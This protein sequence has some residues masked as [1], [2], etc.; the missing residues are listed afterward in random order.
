[1]RK[2]I[3]SILLS[4][5]LVANATISEGTIGSC[6][7]SVDSKTGILKITGNGSM[8]DVSSEKSPLRYYK[9]IVKE[10]YI[11][12]GV[13]DIGR[14]AFYNFKQLRSISIPNTVTSIG[15][16][17]F[18]NCTNLES[19]KL[20][21]SIVIIKSYAFNSCK[22]LISISIPN[23]VREIEPFAFSSCESL[24]SVILSKSLEK[25]GY[26]SFSDCSSLEAITIPEGITSIEYATFSGCSNLKYILLPK[27]IVSIGESA[28]ADCSSL[29]DV[30]C[31]CSEFPN[32]SKKIFDNSYVQYAILHVPTESIVKYRAWGFGSIVPLTDEDYVEK[33]CKTPTINYSNGKISYS[34]DTEGVTFIS[35]ITCDDIQTFESSEINLNFTYTVSVYATKLGYINSPTA[36]KTL[37][38]STNNEDGSML[39]DVNKDGNVDISDIVSIINII[40]KQ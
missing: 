5:S 1:M 34:C 12:S 11:E 18:F 8:G 26:S 14:D 17:A 21:E 19:I 3:T 16:S 33:I 27:S 7:W 10:I 23:S 24:K 13:T 9:D 37:Q 22:S 2:I 31:L 39:G 38:I 32:C 29:Q 20:P 4:I 6:Q 28:F 36:Y 15:N 30:Y 25:L 40:V 35:E